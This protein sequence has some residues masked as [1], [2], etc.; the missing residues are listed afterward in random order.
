MLI[1]T[2]IFTLDFVKLLSFYKNRFRFEF[3]YKIKYEIVLTN[4]IVKKKKKNALVVFYAIIKI[5]T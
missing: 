2:R 1:V 4:K 3:R 5:N